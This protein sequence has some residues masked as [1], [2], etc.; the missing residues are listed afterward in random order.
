MYSY[1]VF[2]F[3]FKW[4]IG[5]KKY[6]RFSDLTNLNDINQE[7]F[8]DWEY[9]PGSLD[10]KE[11]N[12]LYNEKNYFYQFVHP[13]LYDTGADDSILRHFERKEPRSGNVFYKIKI[14]DRKTYTLKVKAINLNLYTTGVGM[15]SFYLENDREDQSSEMDI[16]SINQ[17]GRRVFPPFITDVKSRYE[18][19]ECI[20]IEGLNRRPERY[21]EDFSG[22]NNT[23]YWQ[24]SCFIKHLIEDLTNSIKIEPVIDDRMF[25]NCWYGNK[26][27]SKKVK[28]REQNKNNDDS[29]DFIQNNDFWY[30]Y[31]YVDVNDVT[32][33]D[34]KL[35]KKLTE[36]QTYVRWRECGTL[37]GV[38]RYSFV[39]LSDDS[40]Y[41][42][43]ILTAVHMRTVYARIVEL[44]LIQKASILKF[45]EEVTRV[46]GLPKNKK[47]D[48]GL[49][50]RI[51][52]LYQEYIR[53]VNQIY[54]REV[55]TQDQG[56]E[57]YD[58]ISKTM[59]TED[60][61][62]DL[63]REI[64]ELYQYVSLVD[65]KIRN[66]NAERLNTIAAIFLPAT[67]FAGLFGMNR[68]EDLK[69]SFWWQF[70]VVITVMGMAYFVMK[71]IQSKK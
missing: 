15:L 2:Y 20:E 29:N 65:D 48:A 53:F 16:L 69:C 4:E 43:N 36:E 34:N 14:K 41:S 40:D 10:E 58:L 51:S 64:E 57:L 19:A 49:I 1:H 56:I 46:S 22:Y 12:E 21:R 24:P 55:T 25:V 37:Y 23:Q 71:F 42:K 6:K 5:G 11:A 27:L 26:E 3:P 60:Y 44:V 32:C 31:I 67:L 13:V 39:A 61:I 47:T 35:R 63:D 68:G 54:F 33:K 9:N 17:Y 59:K 30:K 50:D 70:L 18:I 52:S 28:D 38:S 62:K 45:S 8:S 7:K 66:R